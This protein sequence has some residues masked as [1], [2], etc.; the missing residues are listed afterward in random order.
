MSAAV[1][2][3]SSQLK[4]T[5]DI[6]DPYGFEGDRITP[7][8]SSPQIEGTYHYIESAP[9]ERRLP[10]ITTALEQTGHYHDLQSPL[11]TAE[12]TG[13]TR[14]LPPSR[15]DFEPYIK[16]PRITHEEEAASALGG[17]D[18]SNNM[19]DLLVSPLLGSGYS[20]VDAPSMR[21]RR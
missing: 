11:T 15:P 6:D 21:Y 5:W 9:I 17:S 20:V 3:R 2:G 13:G 8:T 10:S 12:S 4:R 14:P 18:R 19:M 7:V 1:M 16:R